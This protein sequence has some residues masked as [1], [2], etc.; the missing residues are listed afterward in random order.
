MMS[1]QDP[2]LPFLTARA[3]VEIDNILLGRP[4]GLSAVQSLSELL[5]NSTEEIGGEIGRRTLMDP[6]TVSVV[7]DA[8]SAFRSDH[9]QSLGE[10]ATE[11]RKVANLLHDAKPEQTRENL[12]RAR[13]FCATLSQMVTSYQQSVYD[14]EPAQQYSW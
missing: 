8:I 11:A 4:S 6:P 3:A 1:V 10:F 2:N 14:L 5:K 7:S 13:L 9:V 12:E